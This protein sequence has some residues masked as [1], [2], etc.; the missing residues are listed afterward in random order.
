MHTFVSIVLVMALIILLATETLSVLC[1]LTARAYG[2]SEPTSAC[3]EP[4]GSSGV[5]ERPES[6][7]PSLHP[8]SNA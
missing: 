3:A 7:R 2:P 6:D 8:R 5:A 1:D 4:I